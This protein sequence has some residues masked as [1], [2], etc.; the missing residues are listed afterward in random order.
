METIS[1]SNGFISILVLLCEI[2]TVSNVLYLQHVISSILVILYCILI[3][4]MSYT[5]NMRLSIPEYAIYV[6]NLALG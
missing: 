4:R 2:L 1:I 6:T 3:I 5:Y